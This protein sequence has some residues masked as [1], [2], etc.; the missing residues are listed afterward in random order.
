M[1][2]HYSWYFLIPYYLWFLYDTVWKGII[3]PY[4]YWNRFKKK[5]PSIRQELKFRISGLHCNACNSYV[6]SQENLIK[7]N[8]VIKK[9]YIHQHAYYLSRPCVFS[10]ELKLTCKLKKRDYRCKFKNTEEIRTSK[11]EV[12]EEIRNTTLHRMQLQIGHR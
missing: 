10:N 4:I 9:L 6:S 3:K 11:K 8:D 12:G 2:L 5:Y 1:D 7:T